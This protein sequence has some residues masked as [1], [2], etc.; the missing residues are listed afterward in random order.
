MELLQEQRAAVA[1]LQA[2]MQQLTTKIQQGLQ[3]QILDS[4]LK[5]LQVIQ[6]A[7]ETSLAYM[8]DV[9]LGQAQHA[10]AT[11]AAGKPLAQSRNAFTDDVLKIKGD[12]EQFKA[13]LQEPVSPRPGKGIEQVPPALMEKVGR[14]QRE[15]IAVKS[16]WDQHQVENGHGFST[17]CGLEQARQTFSTPA[18]SLRRTPLHQSRSTTVPISMSFMGERSPSPPPA[19]VARAPAASSGLPPRW[20]HSVAQATPVSPTSPLSLASPRNWSLMPTTQGPAR[21]SIPA[22]CANARFPASN[23]AGRVVV[24]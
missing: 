7:R 1:K 11:A 24:A 13:L 15:L 14:L 8:E 4:E 23:E 12:I 20:V 9:R 21:N 6:A 19:P 18:Q 3:S 5:L 10:S 2:D 22:R 17:V 16:E